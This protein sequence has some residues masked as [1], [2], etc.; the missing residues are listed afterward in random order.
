[1]PQ[2]YN[3]E[4]ERSPERFSLKDGR[5][6]LSILKYDI[7]PKA[8]PQIAGWIK[9]MGGSFEEVPMSDQDDRYEEDED[10]KTDIHIVFPEGTNV[11]EYGV[12]KAR[13]SQN[14][15]SCD[16]RVY[17]PNGRILAFH[18]HGWSES[19]WIESSKNSETWK[20]YDDISLHIAENRILSDGALQSH[21]EEYQ[22]QYRKNRTEWYAN[23]E[24]SDPEGQYA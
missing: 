5:W 18:Q 9:S 11:K 24:Y 7:H 22:Q 19:M 1:M 21:S 15:I 2:V 10:R 13:N 12:S 14:F 8:L 6:T 17:L 4:L 23:G 3:P 16:G 20:A